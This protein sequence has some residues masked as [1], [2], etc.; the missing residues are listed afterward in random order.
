[1][2]KT[3]LDTVSYIL[4]YNNVKLD[5]F[6]SKYIRYYENEK[7]LAWVKDVYI[8]TDLYSHC[9]KNQL[10]KRTADFFVSHIF[11]DNVEKYFCLFPSKSIITIGDFS[12]CCQSFDN[13]YYEIPVDFLKLI[14]NNREMIELGIY[15]I[16]PKRIEKVGDVDN[17]S[18]IIETIDEIDVPGIACYR[19]DMIS[20][21][22]IYINQEIVDK[23][24]FAFPWLYGAS[25]KDYLDIVHKNMTL[26]K[27]Y[28]IEINKFVKMIKE[29]KIDNVLETIAEM[30]IDMQIEFEI[31]QAQLIKRGINTI[32]GIAV[33]FIPLLLL[34]LDQ[35]AKLMISSLLGTSNLLKISTNIT[36]QIEHVKLVG[37]YNP[38][39]INWK[40]ER[41]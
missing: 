9:L 13:E 22:A 32:L 10:E 8:Q 19:Y 6:D 2:T 15:S 16:M 33:T 31:A 17:G 3:Y 11:N 25:T 40:W 26:F 36:E 18:Q 12:N 28:E 27:K 35:D 21:K 7:K 39:W 14:T 38:L 29:G 24:Y 20:E 34:G 23:V 30:H 1:M 4:K 37:K 41:K 5:S